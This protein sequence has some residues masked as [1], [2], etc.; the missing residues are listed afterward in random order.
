[1]AT[2]LNVKGRIIVVG[3]SG[4]VGSQLISILNAEGY[5]ILGVRS[6]RRCE[7]KNHICTPIDLLNPQVNPDFGDFRASSMILTSWITTPSVFWDSKVNEDWFEAS[8][9]LITRFMRNGGSYVAVTGT[10]A[11]YDWGLNRPLK[12]SDSQNPA[13]LYGQSKLDL[14]NWLTYL[15]VPFLWTRTFAQ[16]GLNE[17]KGRLVPSV[18][19]ALLDSK[20]ATITNAD[21]VRDF[22]FVEDVAK[23]ISVL[24]IGN[25]VGVVNIGTGLGTN[26]GNMA[27][28]IGTM[29]GRPELIKTI[30]QNARSQIVVAE[31]TKL[32]ELLGPFSWTSLDEALNRSIEMR[33]QSLNQRNSL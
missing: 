27:L 18:I 19:D 9:R 4:A 14:L 6:K 15:G 21:G 23:I 11:E 3:C 24:L 30:E 25:T 1:M 22:I 20:V 29:I 32:T 8:K 17:P 13:S 31:I 5:E 33:R 2:P 16:F 12:E 26:I 7:V 28:K 10:C